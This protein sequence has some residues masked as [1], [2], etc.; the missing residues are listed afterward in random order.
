VIEFNSELEMSSRQGF[1]CKLSAKSRGFVVTFQEGLQGPWFQVF[2]GPR[3]QGLGKGRSSYFS[4]D[5]VGN[6]LKIRSTTMTTSKRV[7]MVTCRAVF[8]EAPLSITSSSLN[9]IF[10]S[11]SIGSIV[12]NFSPSLFKSGPIGSI[13]EFCWI[14][15]SQ[16]SCSKSIGGRESEESSLKAT[17][18]LSCLCRAR[19]RWIRPDE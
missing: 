10:I 8:L 18:S 3:V 17:I 19:G 6:V 14:L 11:S 13:E 1:S 5:F 2:N 15:S 9:G 12:S 7:R 4:V 16:T